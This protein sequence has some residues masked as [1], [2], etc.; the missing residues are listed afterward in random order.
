MKLLAS[1][2][3]WLLILLTCPIL[4]VG[5]L[6][7]WAVTAPFDRRLRTLHLYTCAWA[8]LYTYVFPFWTVEVRD[9]KSV[10]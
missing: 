3:L 1:L 10:V 6:V 2:G 9:R 4:F 8:S 7:L 5:A